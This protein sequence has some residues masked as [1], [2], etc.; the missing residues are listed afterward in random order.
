MKK[1]IALIAILNIL[2]LPQTD[3]KEL[4]EELKSRGDIKVTEE[5]NNIYRLKY[6]EGRILHFNFGKTETHHTDSIPTTVIETWNI[7]TML[8]RDMYYFWQEVPVATISNYE[9]V[10]ADANNNGY[11]EI[12]GHV[13]DYEDPLGW[14]P[15]HIF[16]LDSSGTFLDRFAYPD[17]HSLAYRLYDIDLDGNEEL[18]MYMLDGRHIFYKKENPHSLPT[19]PDFIFSLYSGQLDN[20]HFGDFDKNGITD[21]L[22]KDHSPRRTVICEYDMENNNFDSVFEFSYPSGS[23]GGYAIGDFDKDEKKDFVYGGIDG[24]VFVIEAE[25]EHS[26][27]LVWESNV[28]GSHAYWQI[29]TNDIDGNGKSEFWVASTTYYGYTDVTRYTCFEYTDDNE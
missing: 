13:K 5:G 14:L 12:F 7:D 19:T 18:Y 23:S 15:T 8:Y 22:F 16:E 10:I 3:K 20:P 17:S 24:K 6:P 27:Y 9:L 4:L 21:F 2:L 26:Y 25:S 28:E 11:P 1:L 29:F